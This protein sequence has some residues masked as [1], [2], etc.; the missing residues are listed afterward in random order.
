[1]KPIGIMQ[2]RLSPPVGG[3]IQAFPADSWR[4]EFALAREAGLD[5]IEWIYELDNEPRNPLATREGVEEILAVAAAEGVEARSVCADYYMAVRLVEGSAVDGEAVE[6]LLRLLDRVA[7]LG[8]RY[9]VLPF[10][11]ESRLRSDEEVSALG[12]LLARVGPAA[13]EAG[14][15][16]HLETDLPVETLVAVLERA[17]EP[18]RAN[19][20]TGNAASLGRRPEDELPQLSAVLGSVHVKDRVLGGTTVPLGT[21]DA[22]LPG[23]LRLTE[24][25][26]FPGPYILQAAREDGS[27]AELARRNG[28]LL[29]RL[30]LEAEVSWTSS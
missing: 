4:Q 25:A 6:H 24:A 8:A 13:Q 20:D 19:Y 11:D 22:D 16:L 10:V 18:V 28:E 30:L 15:E 1:M 17:G 26:G 5:C 14:V 21:G 29:R 27:E 3:R 12:R 2:G 9:V 23:A 7:L